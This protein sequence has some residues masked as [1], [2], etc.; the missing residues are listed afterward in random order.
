MMILDR[1]M[2]KRTRSKENYL[3]LP[4]MMVE[5]VGSNGQYLLERMFVG[6]EE[7]RFADLIREFCT[8]FVEKRVRTIGIWCSGSSWLVDAAHRNVVL[9]MTFLAGFQKWNRLGLNP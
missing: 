9:A 7:V 6:V 1:E 5:V 4:G 3:L 8:S 2:Q